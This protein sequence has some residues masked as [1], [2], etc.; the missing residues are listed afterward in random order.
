MRRFRFTIASLLAVVLFTGL[1]FAA[2]RGGTGGWGSIVFTSTAGILLP[3][4]P[5]AVHRAGDARA[6]WVGFALFGLGYLLASLIPPVESRLATTR[7]LSYVDSK[8]P[9]RL[10]PV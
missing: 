7:G 8:I 9:G 5:L 1:A 4:V 6:F 10:R 3:S 2:L